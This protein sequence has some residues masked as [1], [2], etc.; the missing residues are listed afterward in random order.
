[1]LRALLPLSLLLA[2]RV[3]GVLAMLFGRTHPLQVLPPE[4]LTMP[5][6]PLP[7]SLLLALWVAEVVAMLLGRTAVPLLL[8]EQDS[9]AL[10]RFRLGLSNPLASALLS[11]LAWMPMGTLFALAAA[12]AEAVC[13]RPPCRVSPALGSPHLLCGRLGPSMSLERLLMPP[14]R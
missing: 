1:M 3:A 7:L 8:A 6:A 5:R 4:W 12:A 11:R 10:L 13:G 9:L 2:L 14:A